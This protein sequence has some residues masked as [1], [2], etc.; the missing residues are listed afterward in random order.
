MGPGDSLVLVTDGL[1]ECANAAGEMLGMDRLSEAI[2]SHHNLSADK[3]IRR[4]CDNVVEFCQGTPQA[5][6]ITAVVI[7]RNPA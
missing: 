6:D 2:G 3:L 4:L 7:K 5:D 1:F